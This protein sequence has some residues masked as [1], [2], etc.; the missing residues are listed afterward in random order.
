MAGRRSGRGARPKVGPWPASRRTEA[1]PPRPAATVVALGTPGGA[2]PPKA[3]RAAC[4]AA[5]RSAAP[6]RCRAPPRPAAPHLAER[7]V[8]YLREE[9]PRLGGQDAAAGNL[10]IVAGVLGLGGGPGAGAR[11]LGQAWAGRGWGLVPRAHART[12][13]CGGER[14]RDRCASPTPGA[15]P[16][17]R[18]SPGTR[19]RSAARQTR[20][21]TAGFPGCWPSRLLTALPRRPAAAA[22]GAAAGAAA[23]AVCT[24]PLPQRPDRA[25]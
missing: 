8:H 18:P 10:H 4:R 12:H 3:A 17:G 5:A 9:A 2:R 11:R 6:S 15:A 25:A 7:V 22:A 20:G 21:S 1:G 13:A 19:P 23:P 24:V 14:P 16:C